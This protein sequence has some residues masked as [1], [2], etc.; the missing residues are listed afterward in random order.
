MNGPLEVLI[1]DQNNRLIVIGKGNYDDIGCLSGTSGYFK[2]R[3]EAK[4]VQN[5]NVGNGVKSDKGYF[6]KLRL[7]PYKF[8]SD[9]YNMGPL[10]LLEFPLIRLEK[11]GFKDYHGITKSLFGA[12]IKPE[13]VKIATLGVPKRN[14]SIPIEDALKLPE[15]MKNEIITA[16]Q[17]MERIT[18]GGVYPSVLEIKNSPKEVE[19]VSDVQEGGWLINDMI[20]VYK[21]PEKAFTLFSKVDIKATARS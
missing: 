5:A 14:Y 12:E 11:L 4:E 18:L 10:P 17:K 3:L 16:L 19:K 8:S 2:F 15:A 9:P 13:N 6:S 7:N 21:G 20:E 1:A